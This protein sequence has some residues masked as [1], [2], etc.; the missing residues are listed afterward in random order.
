MQQNILQ[1][2]TLKAYF[3]A[4]HTEV[5]FH[6]RKGTVVDNN[7]FPSTHS[8]QNLEAKKISLQKKTL[9]NS[10]SHYVAVIFLS[11]Y[12]SPSYRLQPEWGICHAKQCEHTD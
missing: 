12:S 7:A 3:N 5:L 11:S 10:Q 9:K 4:K 8:A 6:L 2:N 1:K